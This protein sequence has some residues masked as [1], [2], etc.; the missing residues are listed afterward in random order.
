MQKLSVKPKPRIPNNHG[1]ETTPAVLARR[2]RISKMLGDRVSVAE[3]AR[4]EKLSVPV[5]WKDV[6]ALDEMWREEH[7]ADYPLK[8][9]RELEQ[10]DQ[11]EREAIN[12]FEVAL[13]PRTIIVGRGNDRQ[14]V[15]IID[16]ELA[17]KCWDRRLEAKK[18]R[19]KMLGFDMSEPINVNIN[20]DKR[21]VNITIQEGGESK[22]YIE[23]LKQALMPGESGEAGESGQILEHEHSKNGGS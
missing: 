22:D 14:A 18:R 21:S 17:L 8:K 15:E 3:I 16:Y 9:A 10:L 1:N 5:I 20:E 11:M 12:L 19:A 7:L 6:R 2:I 4:R 13:E 23:W